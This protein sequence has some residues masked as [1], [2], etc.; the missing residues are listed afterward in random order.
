MKCKGTRSME[1][2]V[3]VPVFE[4]LN[5]LTMYKC[6]NVRGHYRR[7]HQC[8]HVPVLKCWNVLVLNKCRNV[9]MHKCKGTLRKG[10]SCGAGERGC[11]G[12]RDPCN[13][14]TFVFV[15]FLYFY[16]S[17]S[18]IFLLSTFVFVFAG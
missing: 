17:C 9:E 1:S 11:K 7:G 12:A 10:T 5:V 4:C 3:N 18:S 8:W 6:L 14:K 15:F 2:F 13:L 16:S